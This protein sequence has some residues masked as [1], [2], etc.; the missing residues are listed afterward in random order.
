MRWLRP[1][2][3]IGLL[4][5]APYGWG[6]D[7]WPDR[8]VLGGAE[9]RLWTP[10]STTAQ[11]VPSELQTPLGSLWKLFVYGYLQAN[12]QQEPPL[13]CTG[14]DPEQEQ[15]CCDPGESVDR[16]EALIRSCG[17]YFAPERLGIHA[18]D[19][20]SYWQQRQAP[21]WL[22]ELSHLQP[23][24]RVSVSSLLAALSVVPAAVQQRSRE[25]LTG[26]VLHGRG[27]E[28]AGSLG[29]LLG[30]KTYTQATNEWG[31]VGG[32]AGWSDNGTPLWFGGQ[33]GSSSVLTRMAPAIAQQLQQ[34][35][36]PDG[37][38]CV[39][40]R[41]FARYPLAQITRP[42]GAETSAGPLVG[43]YQLAFANGQ[44]LAWQAEPG[45]FWLEQTAQGSPVIWGRFAEP[46]YVARVVDR[47]GD[48]RY[49][50]AARA[51]AIAARSYLQQQASHQ[52]DCLQ[53]DDSSRFQR[54]S[55]HAPSPAALNAARSTD[56]LTL[57]GIEV[58]YHSDKPQANRLS[59]Q[60]AVDWDRAGLDFTA[61]LARAYPAATLTLGDSQQAAD[62]PRLADAQSWLQHQA[63]RWQARLQGEPGFEP[64]AQPLSVCLLPQGRPYADKQ[65]QRIYVR[66]NPSLD[67]RIA[68][69]HEYLHLAFAHHPHGE[70]EAYIEDLAR[71]L[72][73]GEP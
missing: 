49:P 69:T 20:R 45:H 70:D 17:L 48:A 22:Q 5:V 37:S 34:E 66:P 9:P 41:Y 73:R 35:P 71:R 40:V 3:A 33:G 61:I 1:H 64:P 46:E 2:L 59:W 55:P 16:D 26:V 60:Q 13:R 25:V 8:L 27:K 29:T 12:G 51:L 65:A 14:Q 36:Q 19:W 11:P 31:L 15:Y 63:T 32:G 18:A 67:G 53:L 28:A 62:C 72:V 10:P 23:Q 24:Q 4:V 58:Q 44:Q 7:H 21:E 57:H 6:S 38:S 50:Q 56:R 54:V 43:S 47:E 42:H 39:Q 52:G 30:A 68:L